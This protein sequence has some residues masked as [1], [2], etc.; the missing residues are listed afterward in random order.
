MVKQTTELILKN[1]E[2]EVVFRE[3]VKDIPSTTYATFGLY[4][5]PAKFI[6][7]VI[8]YVIK[9]Y[10]TPKM[11]IFDPFAGYGTVGVV[12]RAYGHDYELWDLNPMLEY[13]HEVSTLDLGDEIETKKIINKLEKSKKTFTPAWESIDYWFPK[14]VLPLLSWGLTLGIL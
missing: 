6:P 10:A 12:S 7:Q 2:E 8:A 14:E 4:N 9:T 3:L 5:Y 13:L 1:V 11:S